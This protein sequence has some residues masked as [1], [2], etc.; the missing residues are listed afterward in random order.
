[1]SDLKLIKLKCLEN[2]A[3]YSST[4]HTVQRCEDRYGVFIGDERSYKRRHPVSVSD[5][6]IFMDYVSECVSFSALLKKLKNPRYLP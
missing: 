4:V 3:S 6:L 1:M 5:K 2:K